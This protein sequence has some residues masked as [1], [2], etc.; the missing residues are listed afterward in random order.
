MPKRAYRDPNQPW[1]HCKI[2][3]ITDEQSRAA[4]ILGQFR[5]RAKAIIMTMNGKHRDVDEVRIIMGPTFDI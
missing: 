5:D 2:N 1:R 4:N 3:N